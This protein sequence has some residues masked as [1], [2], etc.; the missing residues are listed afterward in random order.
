MKSK[1]KFTEEIDNIKTVLRINEL[2]Q[3]DENHIILLSEYIFLLTAISSSKDIYLDRIIDL[4][5][6]H[7]NV[8][9][10]IIDKYLIMEEEEKE[11]KQIEKRLSFRKG[12][13]MSL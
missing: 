6:N 12:R 8:F 5:E 1:N 3:N 10:D 2:L 9:L 11:Y 4:D 13:S 7:S